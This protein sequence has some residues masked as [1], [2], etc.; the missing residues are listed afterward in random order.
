MTLSGH[1]GPTVVGV[2][3]TVSGVAAPGTADA[4]VVAGGVSGVATAV[5]AI[6]GWRA[7]AR[8]ARETTTP[9]PTATAMTRTEMLARMLRSLR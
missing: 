7:S 5:A 8:G 2:A 3:G 1:L 4:S 9:Y 6:C